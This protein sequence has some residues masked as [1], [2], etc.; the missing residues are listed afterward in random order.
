ML[1]PSCPDQGYS[2]FQEFLLSQDPTREMGQTRKELGKVRGRGLS[3]VYGIVKQSWTGIYVHDDML[4]D[5]VNI[6]A[7]GTFGPTK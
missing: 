5:V 4:A 7:M 1:R 3:T 6:Q 2:A